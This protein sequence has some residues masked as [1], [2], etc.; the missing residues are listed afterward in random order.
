M[1]PAINQVRAVMRARYSDLAGALL[2][3]RD[4]RGARRRRPPDGE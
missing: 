3:F 1:V 2:K 4:S